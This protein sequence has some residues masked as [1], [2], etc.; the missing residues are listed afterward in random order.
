MG[1]NYHELSAEQFRALAA[2]G[3]GP[4]AIDLLSRSQYSKHVL[5][6]HAIA[7][8]APAAAPA[9]DLLAQVQRED[10]V[11]AAAVVRYPAVGAW[12]YRTAKAQRDGPQLPGA[13][14]EG[15]SAVAAAAASRAGLAAEIDVPAREGI[16]V[17]PSLGVV[18]V[19]VVETPAASTATIRVTPEG[20]EVR[21]SSRRVTIPPDYHAVPGWRPLRTMLAGIVVDDVDPFRLPAAPHLGSAPDL[22]VWRPAFA[23]AWKLLHQHHPTVA[24]EVSAVVTAVVPLA[25]PPDGQVSS[26]SPEAFGAVAMSEPPGP[27]DVALTLAHETQHMKLSA[28]LDMLRLIGPDDGSRYYAPWREDPRPAA[29]LLQGAYAFL[30]VTAF[31]RRQRNATSDPDFLAEMEFARWRDAAAQGCETLLA[32]GQLTSDGE[33]FVATMAQTLRPWLDE[34][35]TDKARRLADEERE[36]HTTRWTAQHGPVPVSR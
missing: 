25:K 35:V 34:P 16:V 9:C 14:P 26:S 23:D 3:G 12:A 7:E 36:R 17:L 19:G 1:T 24:A 21:A 5:L 2:G 31:W 20:T 28:V 32:S 15:L 27:V 33:I 6:L 22:G 4:D 11:A 13:A 29:G 30:G 8:A 10:P 18:E